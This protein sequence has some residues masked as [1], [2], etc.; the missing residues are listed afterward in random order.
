MFGD[1]VE[2]GETRPASFGKAFSFPA[3]RRKDR[4]YHSESGPGC[5]ETR[6]DAACAGQ[7]RIGLTG[8][9]RC[10]PGRIPSRCR[11]SVQALVM[12][13]AALV[14][15]FFFAGQAAGQSRF[16]FSGDGKIRLVGEK[17][18]EVFEGNYR[19]ESGRYDPAALMLICRVF[20]AP[21]SDPASGISIRLIEYLDFLQDSLRPDAVIRIVSGYRSPV[22]NRRLRQDGALAAKASLHQYGMAADLVMEAVPAEKVWKTVRRVGFGGA[23]K[24]VHVDTG[25]ARFWDERT[26]GVGTG[27]SDDNKLIGLVSDFDRYRPGESVT[28]RF[29]RMTAF[30]I[31]VDP[32]FSL[33]Q[34]AEAGGG[35]ATVAS[36][37]PSIVDG[38][39]RCPVFSDIAQMA[40]FTFRI[41]ED[42]PPGRY[43]V[44]ARFCGK[45]WPAMPAKASTAPFQVMGR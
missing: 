6:G 45:K 31:G 41:P 22:Y 44:R 9:G 4:G 27:I 35:R 24:T 39:G 3:F 33:E 1:P 17:T 40:A 21:C 38:G 25:P 12:A 34:I 20:G 8:R 2:I 5:Q 14:L 32:L 7:A 43:A 10:D 30:P 16:F 13:V 37:T 18:E 26:S 36:F 42:L 11:A 23:G 19:A 29:V 15:V 28:L